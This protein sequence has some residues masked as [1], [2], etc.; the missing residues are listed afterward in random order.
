MYTE[1]YTMQCLQSNN[2]YLTL[3]CFHFFTFTL[4]IKAYK[5]KPQIMLPTNAIIVVSPIIYNT[6]PFSCYL[7]Y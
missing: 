7:F 4:I 6:I 5:F 1:E 3:S 2:P